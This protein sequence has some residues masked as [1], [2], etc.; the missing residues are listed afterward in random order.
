[1]IRSSGRAPGLLTAA[2]V[3]ITGGTITGTPVGGRWFF[4]SAVAAKTTSATLTGAE[5]MGG[6]I[7]GNQGAAGAATYTLPL[8]TDLQ[9][10]LPADFGTGD[11]FE[12]SVT[13]IS[14]VAAEDITVA[15]NTGTTLVGSGDVA[16]NAAATDKS[17]GTFLVRK[18]GA[19]AFSIYRK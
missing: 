5:L 15:G 12:F 4:T 13:N 19:N 7:T 17:A 9:T 2:T 16:S 3:A 10:A 6:I 14:T 18:T 11:T 1:M 8:G